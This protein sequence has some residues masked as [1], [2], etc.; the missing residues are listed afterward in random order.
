MKQAVVDY[1]IKPVRLEKLTEVGA[2]IRRAISTRINLRLRGTNA[3]G[4][5]SSGG[6][7]IRT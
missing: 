6:R 5:I 3:Q 7:R 2:N 1:V 4:Q